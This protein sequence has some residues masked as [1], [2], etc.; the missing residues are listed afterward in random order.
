MELDLSAKSIM[1]INRIRQAPKALLDFDA[2]QQ[3]PPDFIRIV[4]GQPE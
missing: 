2:V 4:G 3:H 1:V